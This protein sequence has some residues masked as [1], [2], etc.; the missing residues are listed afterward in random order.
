LNRAGKNLPASRKRV[1]ERA[2]DE[3]RAM[4]A[5]SKSR[6]RKTRKS[7]TTQR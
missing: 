4:N 5:R 6:A 2:K 3:L 7:R 1:L